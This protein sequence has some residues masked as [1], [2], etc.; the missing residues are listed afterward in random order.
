MTMPFHPQPKPETHKKVKARKQRGI[1]K[2]RDAVRAFIYQLDGG[3]C[4]RCRKRLELKTDDWTRLAN[5]NEEPRRSQG[6]DKTNPNHCILLCAACHALVTAR[7]IW[8]EI[9]EPARGCRGPVHFRR[10]W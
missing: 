5:V 4:R 10:V 8:I 1:D 6:G 7:K 2:K 9:V 3:R